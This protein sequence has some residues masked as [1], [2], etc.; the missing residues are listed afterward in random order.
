MASQS[1]IWWLVSM[2]APSGVLSRKEAWL[3]TNL[4][5]LVAAPSRRRGNA[6]R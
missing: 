6:L 2:V 3:P 5:A 4:R 1:V